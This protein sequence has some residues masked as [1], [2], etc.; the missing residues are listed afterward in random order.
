VSVALEKQGKIICGGT[1]IGPRKV[2]TAAHCV[3]HAD[4][5]A[6]YEDFFS[7]EAWAFT[8]E[9][10]DIALDLAVLETQQTFPLWVDV[11]RRP[12]RGESLW[13]I[14][15]AVNP[16]MSYSSEVDRTDIVFKVNDE[17]KTPAFRTFP[18]LMP[19]ASGSGVFAGSEL[20]GVCSGIDS[21]YTYYA[22]PESF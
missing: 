10:I 15:H 20:V 12:S 3:K 2:I 13:G 8:V 11:G 1:K 21:V 7:G 22:I 16:W 18:R 17:I 5:I 4:A 14:H 9:R 19:G 6:S